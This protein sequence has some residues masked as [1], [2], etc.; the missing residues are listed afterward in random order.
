MNRESVI[1]T[2]K[3]MDDIDKLN[4]SFVKYIN[5]DIRNVNKDVINY[6]KSNGS[7][8]LYSECIDGKNGYI[9][10]DYDTFFVAEEKIRNIIINMPLSL[11]EIEKAKYLYISIAKAIS[12]DINAI[13]EKND[14]FSYVNVNVINNIW[15]SLK[16]MKA[17]NQSYCKLYL[18]LCSLVGIKCDI[19]TV[20]NRGFL[21]NKLNIDNKS[22][23][24]NLTEDVPF[25]ESGF[26]TR[27]FSDFNDVIDMDIKIGYMK[28]NYFEGE[29][30]KVL[31]ELNQSDDD[32]I[33][34]FL[35]NTQKFIDINNVSPIE[36]GIIFDYLFGK[37]C[38]N[39]D[40]K[41]NNLYLNDIYN[42]RKHFILISYND[43]YYCYNYNKESFVSVSKK[44]LVDN[45]E[46]EKIGVYLNEDMPILYKYKE[47]V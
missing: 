39:I 3:D 18:Y 7:K 47:V 45:I 38:S 5:I 30:D 12:Y 36:L 27:Y 4:D 43:K 17:T 28:N 29:L 46:S 37:Y 35:I 11:S 22:L 9:Y 26:K 24:V 6:L 33:Y 14:L 23:I 15:G 25:I 1:L 40:I 13:P 31:C 20:N 42:N 19:I 32:F 44:D 2:I 10:V 8:Y 16:N 34:N 41:I 21:C